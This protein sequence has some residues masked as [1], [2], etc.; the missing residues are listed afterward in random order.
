MITFCEVVPDRWFHSLYEYASRICP[1]KLTRVA[2]EVDS[3]DICITNGVSSSPITSKK[4]IVV[5][6]SNP[7]RHD[8]EETLPT[9]QANMEH[10][11]AI[12][13][14][15]LY[16]SYTSYVETTFKKPVHIVPNV[17]TPLYPN[18][19][20][21]FGSKK[22]DL[23]IVGNHSPLG[24]SHIKP[25]LIAELL[26]K[27]CPDMIGTIFYM[28][29]PDDH[30]YILDYISTLSCRSKVRLFVKL[31]DTTIIGHF[32]KSE[33]K[34]VFLTNSVMDDIHPLFYDILFAKYPFVHSSKLLRDTFHMNEY[35]D[36]NNLDQAI[37]HIKHIIESGTYSV[38]DSEILEQLRRVDPTPCIAELLDTNAATSKK[39]KELEA[40]I[41]K[42]IAS[43]EL[44]IENSRIPL[45]IA[46]DN[47]STENTKLFIKTLES[48]H[49][50]FL[51]VGQGDTWEGWSTRLKAYR[52]VLDLLPKDKV[53]I[54]SDARDVF[55]VRDS[56]AFMDGFDSLNRAKDKLVVCGEMIC[57][58]RFIED[59]DSSKPA[60]QNKCLD[61]Y[62]KHYGRAPPMRQFVNNGLVCGRVD[63]FLDYYTWTKT[64]SI[65]DDQLLLATYTD[66]YPERIVLDDD[67]GL[68]HS[69]VF[70]HNAGL[71]HPTAQ[72]ADAPSLATLAGRSVF[73]LHIPGLRFKGQQR[74][75]ESIKQLLTSG[76]SDAYLRNDYPY[77]MLA[78]NS[79]K[80][81][82]VI[83]K[84]TL[85]AYY[86]CYKNP[87]SFLR[88][89]NS[90]QTHYPQSTIVVSNDG[91]NDY[92]SYCASVTSNPVHYT[93][94]PKTRPPSKQLAYRT[95]EPL[96]D[97]LSRLWKSF[98]MYK[99]SHIVLLEDDVQI[100]RRH[101]LPFQNTI[102]GMN[103]AYELPKAMKDVLITKGYKGHFY[104]GGCGGCVI[105]KLFY[106]RIPFSEVEELMRKITVPVYASD[107]A[108]VFL[109]LYYGGSINS[110]DEFG[111]MFYPNIQ[112]LL[113]ENKLAFL[114]QYKLDYNNPLSDDES[115]RLNPKLGLND[116][117]SHVVY[118]NLEERTD[119]RAKIETELQ[120]VFSKSKI[121]R[122]NAQKHAHGGIGC[123]LSQVGAIEL[124]KRMKWP[125]VLVVE[126]DF[127]F[128]T[129]DLKKGEG[130]FIEHYK[131]AHDV[132]L[133]GGT[134]VHCTNTGK[135]R[136]AA[137][138][139]GYFVES[140]YYDTL[141]ENFKTG[142]E[143]FMKTNNYSEYACDRYWNR[144]Q[145]KDEWYIANPMICRQ[146]KGYSDIE[147]K[148]VDY[149]DYF[150]LKIV[151]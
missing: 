117:I 39:Q 134:F 16:R 3:S 148:D 108:L 147:K 55:C 18:N 81:P 14:N 79:A 85:G 4:T 11:S 136:Y 86:Q 118:I 77:P 25:L 112:S 24:R 141:L 34:V 31:T 50:Q 120:T 52:Q 145:I 2:T 88:V 111:E 58:G 75:Y 70:G 122:Y 105:S 149:K 54:F 35:Y 36:Y 46:Y 72:N 56:S 135:V 94:Y 42:S 83:H 13:L 116:C 78:W 91:G 9:L 30:T 82:Q 40:L 37:I 90:F 66:L 33:N 10:V 128:A 101:T 107:V 142:V 139:I 71:I 130:S 137:S 7:L 20:Y 133:L 47:E 95:V 115:A 60:V 104:L 41:S 49:W 43:S 126:D 44:H 15:E 22:T 102:N 84:Q 23:V 65:P 106:E 110:Y 97:F 80:K 140:H 114:H 125:N 45:V 76:Y 53:V 89:M 146:L 61:N 51:I 21:S 63:T 1:C 109:A 6:N 87:K 59:Y 127:V 119:R 96:L 144:L 113:V 32:L 19:T 100:L 29:A 138:A 57:D 93:Y 99:E 26:V 28:N 8:L 12:W 62:W 69:S 151:D 17:W 48:N 73:F 124:A 132:I 67:L 92:S 129:E 123:S 143:M 74:V 150:W 68:F 27:A 5:M 64:S 121:H 38:C 131:K 98:P 103:P